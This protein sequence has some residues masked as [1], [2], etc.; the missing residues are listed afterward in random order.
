[1]G[2][3]TTRSKREKRNRAAMRK[4][5]EAIRDK[6]LEQCLGKLSEVTGEPP[7]KVQK[8]EKQPETQPSSDI[9]IE[10]PTK[11]S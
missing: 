4:K 9:Q 8:K 6:R 2:R 3:S 11:D 7:A 5:T 1:M 10:E